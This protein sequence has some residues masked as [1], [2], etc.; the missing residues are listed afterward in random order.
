[1]AVGVPSSCEA[2]ASA[3]AS[4]AACDSDRTIIARLAS[5][6]RPTTPN[7]TEMMSAR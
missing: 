7:V 1:M 3:A 4:A 6:A 2:A 5:M